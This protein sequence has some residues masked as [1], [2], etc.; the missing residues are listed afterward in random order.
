[1]EFIE[2]QT[3]YHYRIPQL[4]KLILMGV[5][6]R[7]LEDGEVKVDDKKTKEI[8]ENILKGLAT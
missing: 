5:L 2:E 1:M 4:E 7:L 6:S 8:L 3:Y